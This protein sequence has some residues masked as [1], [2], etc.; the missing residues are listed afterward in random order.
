MD[1]KFITTTS[2]RL[3]QLSIVAGQLIYLSDRNASYY[4]MGGNRYLMSSMRLVSSLPTSGNEQE[5]VLY[6]VINA[7]G[8]VDSYVWDPV[9]SEFKQLSGYVATTSS[10]GLV[11]PDGTTITIDANGVISCHAEVTSLPS[12]AITYDNS[13]SGATAT[14]AQ[15]MLDDTYSIAVSA[16]SMGSAASTWIAN[17]ST[18]M[19]SVDTFDAAA[20]TFIANATT[21]FAD[22]ESRLQAVEAIANAALLVEDNNLSS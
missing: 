14:N 17:A 1:V 12:S 3:S 4:D 7:A 11:K 9:S 8:H 10:L 2:N 15:D 16:Q 22:I 13:T 21:A 18:W 6:G 20:T 19:S 5:G